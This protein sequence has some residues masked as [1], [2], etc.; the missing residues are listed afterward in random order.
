MTET[1][2]ARARSVLAARRDVLVRASRAERVAD[3]LREAVLD[4]TFLPGNRLSE[5]DICTALGIARNTLRE[6]FRI[7]ANEQLVVHELNRGMF[8]RVPSAADVTATY[9]CRQV[10]ECAAI[11]TAARRVASGGSCDLTAMT[12]ALTS[13]DEYAA[14]GD[15][16]PAGTADVEFHKA[17]TALTG[18]IRITELMQSVW[19]ELRLI[20][21]VID[22]PEQF[23][24]AYLARNHMI[25]EA[26]DGQDF[27]SAENLLT[28][29]LDDAEAQVLEAY[30]RKFDEIVDE[31][32]G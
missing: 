20:F 28:R 22:D 15:W 13:A 7:L 4:G 21:Y 11:R 8:V 12:A 31:R 14:A 30:R 26:L 2:E 17:L 16:A 29:Y 6:A 10:I 1:G 23:H 19:H 25:H 27:D 32:F 18:S 5:P 9:D 24:G 3:L